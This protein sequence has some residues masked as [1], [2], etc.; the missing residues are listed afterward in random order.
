MSLMCD[1]GVQKIRFI[2]KDGLKDL[3]S[4]KDRISE[5]Y[6]EGVQMIKEA[7]SSYSK[8]KDL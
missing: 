6:R 1:V 3:P 5:Y 2:S 8:Y 4:F 7:Q